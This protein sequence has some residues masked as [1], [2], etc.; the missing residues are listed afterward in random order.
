MQNFIRNNNITDIK[1]TV[2]CLVM[3]VEMHQCWG[4][5]EGCLV[6]NMLNKEK[7]TSQFQTIFWRLTFYSVLSDTHRVKKHVSK[8]TWQMIPTKPGMLQYWLIARWKGLLKTVILIQDQL[9][10]MI[11][12]R[13]IFKWKSMINIK[14]YKYEKKYWN[15]WIFPDPPNW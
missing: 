12:T 5:A 11:L 4:M 3:S 13:V 10:K 14:Q 1:L 8:V 15:L 6:C 7:G 9:C 2:M